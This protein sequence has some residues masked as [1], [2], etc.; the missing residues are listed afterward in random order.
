LARINRQK[1]E[2]AA[3]VSQQQTDAATY[4]NVTG[5]QRQKDRAAGVARLES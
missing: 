3:D 2:I 5:R 1:S 4:R